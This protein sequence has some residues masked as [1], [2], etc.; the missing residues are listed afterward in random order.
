MEDELVNLF[1]RLDTEGVTVMA[2]IYDLTSSH[3]FAIIFR[4]VPDTEAASSILKS[5]YKSVWKLRG[6]DLASSHLNSLRA[7]AHRH[8][9]DYKLSHPKMAGHIAIAPS[10]GATA[11]ESLQNGPSSDKDYAVLKSV[12]LDAIPIKD[13]SQQMRCTE[14]DLKT[15]IET[16]VC[17]IVRGKS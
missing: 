4:I 17:Q 7:L 15:K 13:L 8:A 6:Q 12:Y 2:K 5:V 1:D 10:R 9:I 3:L 14:D 11:N 16:L